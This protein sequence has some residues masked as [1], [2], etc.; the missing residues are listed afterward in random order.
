MRTNVWVEF[1]TLFFSAK[2]EFPLF[3]SATAGDLMV[4]YVL[5]KDR[6]KGGL[7]RECT[8]G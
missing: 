2:V 8:D 4:W 5:A 3:F 6:E 7:S 1:V